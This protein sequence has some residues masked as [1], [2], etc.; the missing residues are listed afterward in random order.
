[1]A[2]FGTQDVR[3]LTVI[4]ILAL[5]GLVF[6][7]AMYGIA[8]PRS[9]SPLE[10][11]QMGQEGLVRVGNSAPEEPVEAAQVAPNDAPSAVV[12]PVQTGNFQKTSERISR[13]YKMSMRV[14][15]YCPCPICC[16]PNA[17]GVTASGQ[18]VTTNGGRFVAA[19][20]DLLPFGTRI[21]IAGYYHGQIVPV[22]DRGKLVYGHRLDVFFPSHQQ[23]REWGVKYLEVTIYPD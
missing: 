23:A 7:A 11:V 14:T 6:I 20:T 2:E 8:R 16:G 15:A 1:M 4:S 5:A 9:L 13:P 18:R 10:A 17:Q 19:D 22:L 3:L 12:L 21:S